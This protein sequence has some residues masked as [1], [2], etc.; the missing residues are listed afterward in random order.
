MASSRKRK[1][2]K[3]NPYVIGPEGD[4]EL[5][6][7]PRR[8]NPASAPIRRVLRPEDMTVKELLQFDKE[9]QRIKD[10]LRAALIPEEEEDDDECEDEYEAA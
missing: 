5:V 7:G 1:Q 3:T 6:V 4:D 8:R 2:T 10:K 9:A